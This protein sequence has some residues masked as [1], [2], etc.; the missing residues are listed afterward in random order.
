MRRTVALHRYVLVVLLGSCS[1]LAC[2]SESAEP[3][4][5]STSISGEH[6]LARA[7]HA[8]GHTIDGPF[9]SVEGAPTAG[10]APEL[11]NT[12]TAYAVSLTASGDGHS[13]WARFRPRVAGR[14][15]FY[16]EGNAPLSVSGGD[17]RALCAVAAHTVPEC[18]RLNEVWLYDLAAQRDFSLKLGP[19][20]PSTVT[21]VIEQE[22]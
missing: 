21:V 20:P 1:T 16:I 10:A 12:H 13:G 18:E 4:A 2:S 8:C 5:C 3:E 6:E 7:R 11:R 22:N 17:E 19:T 14:Y 9:A 15:A